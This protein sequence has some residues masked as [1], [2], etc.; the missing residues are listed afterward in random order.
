MSLG[1]ESIK[2]AIKVAAELRNVTAA[3]F[4]D[5]K[6]QVMEAFGYVPA[7][8]QVQAIVESGPTI[9]AELKDADHAERAE[10]EAYAINELKIEAADVE[11]FIADALDWIIASLQLF[12]SGKGLSAE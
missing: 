10:L 12:I 5:G 2:P 3:A 11:G 1:I 6:F 7:L 9:L 8:M 4:A